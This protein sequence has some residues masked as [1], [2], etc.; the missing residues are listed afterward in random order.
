MAKSARLVNSAR[1]RATSISM[2]FTSTL[3]V[4][5]F[6]PKKTAKEYPTQRPG[7]R[8]STCRPN[9]EEAQATVFDLRDCKESP[10]P[11][12]TATTAGQRGGAPTRG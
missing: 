12:V 7:P 10:G 1:T 11:K 4:I 5:P 2:T 6:P 8:P 9:S 3:G